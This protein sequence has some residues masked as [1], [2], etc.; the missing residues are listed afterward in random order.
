MGLESERSG[1]VTE[2]VLDE[3]FL[4]AAA[5]YWHPV[6][7]STDVRAAPAH[8]ELCEVPLV[9]WRRPS[10][11]VAALVDRCPHRGVPL[12]GGAVDPAG[13]LRC[14]YH[15]WAFDGAGRC[16]DIPQ[17][18]GQNIPDVIAA[19]PVRV[20]EAAGLVWACLVDETQQARP[21]PRFPQIEDLGWPSYVGTVQD[22]TGQA[23]RQVENF[24]DIGH[25]SVLHTDTFGNAEVLAVE[26]Y[27]V[28]RTDWTVEA[29]YRYPSVNPVAEP[30]PDGRRPV[31]ETF[32]QYRIELPFAVWL[33]GA[34][35][36]GSVMFSVSA[37]TSATTLRL[38]WMSAFDPAVHGD[39]LVDGAGLQAVEDRIWAP[40]KA[41][42]ES[43]RPARVFA[44]TEAHRAFDALG[45]AYRKALRD[46]GFAG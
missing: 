37:P 10:G 11:D 44:A 46:L 36:P 21:R 38:Y 8:A 13:R 7:R 19:R 14:G 24:C 41:I 12:S 17:Q 3:A 6:A 29:D 20:E 32:F 27:A 25:F 35:G 2:A 39:V 28:H 22:W 26:P 43:Q 5:R 16:V 42:V 4:A 23:A 18:P 40:D 31:G 9:L 33:G 34:N 1:P 45:V 15:A 30:G